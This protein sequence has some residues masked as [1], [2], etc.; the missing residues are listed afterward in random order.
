[1]AAAPTRIAKCLDFSKPIL[2]TLPWSSLTTFN[3]PAL[4]SKSVETDQFMIYLSN[5]V[6]LLKIV[7]HGFLTEH[8]SGIKED[9]VL[10][11]QES[12]SMKKNQ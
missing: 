4:R 3:L 1:M 7:I 12:S 8:L 5:T 9:F 6:S 11:S 10:S 2:R